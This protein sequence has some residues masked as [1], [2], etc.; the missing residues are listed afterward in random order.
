MNY[1]YPIYTHNS[2]TIF[3]YS[4]K[5]LFS[6]VPLTSF[7]RLQDSMANIVRKVNLA[8]TASQK[9]WKNIIYYDKND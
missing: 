7:S 3:D 8:S 9:S 2:D 1:T 6:T 5:S 4:N